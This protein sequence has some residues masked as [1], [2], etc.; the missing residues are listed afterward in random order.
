MIHSRIP[1][2]QSLRNSMGVLLKIKGG[3]QLQMPGAP[4]C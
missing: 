1:S 4:I 2:L 3:L